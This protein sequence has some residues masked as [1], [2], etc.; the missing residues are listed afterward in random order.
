MAK[1]RDLLEKSRD[2]A[3]SG[4]GKVVVSNA[5]ADTTVEIAGLIGRAAGR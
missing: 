3:L 5:S 1:H 4:L 2:T